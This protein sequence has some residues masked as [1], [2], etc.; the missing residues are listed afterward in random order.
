MEWLVGLPRAKGL[1]G[2]VSVQVWGWVCVVMIGL[3]G[4]VV[5][6]GVEWVVRSRSSTRT[7]EK[8]KGEG[9]GMKMRIPVG[10]SFRAG[11]GK[12]REGKKTR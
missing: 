9:E 4:E 11:D 8:G 1:K 7:K 10:D 3:L 6:W 12:G 2:G 5:G